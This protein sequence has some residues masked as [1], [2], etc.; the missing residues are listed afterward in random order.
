MRRITLRFGAFGKNFRV[1]EACVQCRISNLA[2][3]ESFSSALVIL[4]DVWRMR[5]N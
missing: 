1:S 2:V 5:T 3:T 4:D